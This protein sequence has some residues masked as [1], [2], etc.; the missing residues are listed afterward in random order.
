MFRRVNKWH[1]YLGVLDFVVVFVVIVLVVVGLVEGLVV[2][3]CFAVAVGILVA[4]LGSLVFIWE[5]VFVS[6]FCIWYDN[7]G[8]W[9]RLIAG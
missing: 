1:S 6:L 7:R 2:D 8:Y 4:L 5:G 9:N 3:F